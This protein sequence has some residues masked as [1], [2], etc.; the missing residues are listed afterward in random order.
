VILVDS[1]IWA[2]HIHHPVTTL[3]DLLR[4]QTVGMHPFVIGEIML[5][6][7]AVRVSTLKSLRAL[8]AVPMAHDDE[9]IGLIESAGLFGSGIGYVDTHLLASTLLMVGGRLWTRDRRLRATAERL[10]IAFPAA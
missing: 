10:G 9:V 3:A 2:D 7:L 4:N 6:N 8:Y 1:S 5:G